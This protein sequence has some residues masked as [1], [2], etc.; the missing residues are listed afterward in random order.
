MGDICKRNKLYDG[1]I[2]VYSVTEGF[3]TSIGITRAFK[4]GN[5]IKKITI[6][7]SDDMVI[8]GYIN[9][10]NEE[11]LNFDINID[12]PFYSCFLQFLGEDQEFIIEDDDT[13]GF[14]NKYLMVKKKDYNIKVI[15]H[16][17]EF[18]KDYDPEKFRIFIKNYGPDPRSKIENYDDKV[19]IIKL[20]RNLE[21][22][23]SDEYYQMTILEY[24]DRLNYQNKQNQMEL[25]K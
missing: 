11:I 22:I 18:A 15:F 20:F 10:S 5:I 2:L 7:H 9:E 16:N 12:D 19:R 8:K 3:T 6:D 25:K 1:S 13:N 17:Y 21:S 4:I 23:A 14:R 24:L